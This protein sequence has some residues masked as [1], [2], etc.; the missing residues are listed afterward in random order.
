MTLL[1]PTFRTSKR[2]AQSDAAGPPD[3]GSGEY[4]ARTRATDPATEAC[5]R[6]SFLARSGRLLAECADL[7]AALAAVARMALPHLQ[8]WCILDIAAAA[9]AGA[10]RRLAVVHPDPAKQALAREL[11]DSYE[12]PFQ[13]VL[14]VAGVLRTGEPVVVRNVPDTQLLA[15][16]RDERQLGLLRQLGFGTYMVAPLRARGQVLGALTFVAPDEERVFD[17]ADRLLAQDLALRCALALDNRRLY[18]ESQDASRAKMDFLAII[19]HELRTPITAVLGYAELLQN[20]VAGPVNDQQSDWLGRLRIGSMQLGRIV[21]ELIYFAQIEAGRRDVQWESVQVAEVVEA[22]VMMVRESAEERGLA[23]H[24]DT[25]PDL[26]LVTDRRKLHYLLANLLSNANKFTDAGEVRVRVR[27]DEDAVVFEV[28]DTGIG[29]A[30]EHHERIFEPFW[31]VESPNTRSRNG[32]GLGLSLARRLLDLMGG[33]ISLA[34][35]LGRGTRCA[36]RL[37]LRPAP[38]PLIAYPPD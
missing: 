37:P 11:R 17:E 2:H 8:A 4:A 38:R 24:V 33:D 19:S 18:R 5:A 12:E 27:E 15:I 3:G 34:S 7:S 26:L 36:F 31:Q 23:V 20:G 32:S 22:A 1:E 13:D 30:P 25:P 28:E 10:P 14:G 9:E 16:V 21:D 35:E 29:I 6:L